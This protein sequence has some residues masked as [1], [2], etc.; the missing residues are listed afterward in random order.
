MRPVGQLDDVTA[1]RLLTQPLAVADRDVG[2]RLGSE[3]GEELVVPLGRADVV[4]DEV[5]AGLGSPSLPSVSTSGT[6]PSRSSRR[7][8]SPFDATA[9]PVVAAAA[10][11]GAAAVVGAATEA[12]VAAATGAVVGAVVAAVAGAV[13]GGA[14]G[15]VVGATAAG[16]FVGGAAAAAA[17]GAAAAGAV[18]AA[19]AAPPQAASNEAAL[20]PRPAT[21]IQRRNTRR[22]TLGALES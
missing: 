2:A 8:S 10:A 11:V 9:G 13:V 1:G 4:P 5:V 21:P 20:A 12:V 19:C 18:V 3:L 22:V 16:A 7:R 6:A 15:A 14:A 17:V